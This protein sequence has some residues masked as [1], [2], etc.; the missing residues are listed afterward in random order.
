[1]EEQD[2]EKIKRLGVEE[3]IKWKKRERGKR[4]NLRETEN[5]K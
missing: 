5:E 2:R 3:R 1:M 4:K